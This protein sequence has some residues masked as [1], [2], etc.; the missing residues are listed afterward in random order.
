MSSE[1]LKSKL[2]NLQKSLEQLHKDECNKITL[3][4]MK[5]QK[6]ALEQVIRNLCISLLSEEELWLLCSCCID[7][8]DSVHILATKLNPYQY[9]KNNN[10]IQGLLNIL[11]TTAG[12]LDNLRTDFIE[13]L[14]PAILLRLEKIEPPWFFK[15]LMK[16]FKE[17]LQHTVRKKRHGIFIDNLTKF[18]TLANIICSCGDFS[19]QATLIEIIFRVGSSEQIKQYAGYLFPQSTEIKNALLNVKLDNFDVHLRA[20]QNAINTKFKTIFS[21]KCTSVFLDGIAVTKPEDVDMWVDF[22]IEFKSMSFFCDRN[23]L[24][25]KF[26]KNQEDGWETVTV[27]VDS[28][29]S[30]ISSSVKSKDKMSV[31]EKIIRFVLEAPCL[32]VY[33][34]SY[35]ANEHLTLTLLE[36]PQLKELELE[37]LP[38]MF[39]N[40]YNNT[41]HPDDFSKSYNL[42]NSILDAKKMYKISHRQFIANSSENDRFED[43]LI[44]GNISRSDSRPSFSVYSSPHSSIFSDN[45][46]VDK[47]Q[48]VSSRT[49]PNVYCKT[50]SR[51]KSNLS[52]QLIRESAEF[53]YESSASEKANLIEDDNVIID[54]TFN[55]NNKI[56]MLVNNIDDRLKSNAS[57]NFNSNL[58]RLKCSEN[59][60]HNKNLIWSSSSEEHGTLLYKRTDSRSKL[61][62]PVLTHKTTKA[63]P[64]ERVSVYENNLSKEETRIRLSTAKSPVRKINEKI[65]KST[66]S[67]N[68]TICIRQCNNAKLLSSVDPIT[69]RLQSDVKEK[70]QEALTYKSISRLTE[71]NADNYADVNLTRLSKSF[72]STSNV[73]INNKL[74]HT[75]TVL[76]EINNIVDKNCEKKAE[77]KQ[78]EIQKNEKLLGSP[79]ISITNIE[80]QHSIS[81]KHS[82]NGEIVKKVENGNE[83]TQNFIEV[84][85]TLKHCSGNINKLSKTKPSKKAMEI[86]NNKKLT[87]LSK[88]LKPCKVKLIKEDLVE[89]LNQIKIALNEKSC[90]HLPNS[91]LKIKDIN[92]ENDSLTEEIQNK[93]ATH[94]IQYFS[95]KHKCEVNMKDVDKTNA[96]RPK[97]NII[98]NMKIVSGN[99]NISLKKCRRANCRKLCDIND[100][101]YL[102]QC[103]LQKEN[104]SHLNL[105]E[106]ASAASNNKENE[107]S[108]CEV[109][110]LSQDSN[111][112]FEKCKT[113]LQK[114]RQSSIEKEKYRRKFDDFLSELLNN[115]PKTPDQSTPYW[116]K[117]K[118]VKKVPA[119]K[120]QTNVKRT[121][122]VAGK[123]KDFDYSK[124]EKI[125]NSKINNS[126][127]TINRNKFIKVK[128]NINMEEHDGMK[129]VRKPNND[130][131]EA[132]VSDTSNDM[133]Y[134]ERIGIVGGNGIDMEKIKS[135]ICADSVEYKEEIFEKMENALKFTSYLTEES[136]EIL[137]GVIPPHRKALYDF[138]YL[139]NSNLENYYK[140]NNGELMDVGDA[141]LH[142]NI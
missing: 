39:G 91:S 55:A 99:E 78:T 53:G 124:K 61:S 97:I 16:T 76:E 136:L 29:S 6:K 81:Y 104:E 105:I 19:Y 66:V 79:I 125:K 84:K 123:E 31:N 74:E 65:S 43:K 101:S 80:T 110:N 71:D 46:S 44:N 119:H 122:N 28:V 14:S 42:D 56:S 26:D 58:S 134:T 75:I 9:S 100:L 33:P 63:R 54:E 92:V 68:E 23:C 117:S 17:C 107:V 64:V 8:I 5:T 18:C 24:L 77:E 22:N 13:Y 70:G 98:S 118:K 103:T 52:S 35:Q 139:I 7:Y 20:V 51:Q 50:Y 27:M 95:K 2:Q 108:L 30:V 72:N 96:K 130:R 88:T 113:I 115:P 48:S 85:N 32:C 38:Q 11:T 120:L 116:F 126:V 132:N 69:S 128:Q 62:R 106:A 127:L 140:C 36:S 60:N 133:N 86:A 129:F 102:E 12:L 138:I 111:F 73:L 41:K 57:E 3:Y 93:T 47:F 82:N 49:V 89:K 34:S 37:I 112:N 141:D 121:K 1:S 137:K 131:L 25:D 142:N 67:I 135:W 94:S 59:I 40:K 87:Y 45:D 90:N 10:I 21:I 109:R 114:E 83:I 4:V 15:I